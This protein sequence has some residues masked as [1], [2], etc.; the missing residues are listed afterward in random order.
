MCIIILLIIIT[1]LLFNIEFHGI[2]KTQR[3][4]S[5]VNFA[6]W[7]GL[8]VTQPHIICMYPNLITVHLKCLGFKSKFWPRVWILERLGYDTYIYTVC[9]K[10]NAHLIPIFRSPLE[11]GVQKIHMVLLSF[12]HKWDLHIQHS[13]FLA[14]SLRGATKDSELHSRIFLA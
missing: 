2:H 13:G 5:D 1:T 12:S 4:P 10:R 9:V 8:E 7:F 6:T 11:G 3:I 14:P